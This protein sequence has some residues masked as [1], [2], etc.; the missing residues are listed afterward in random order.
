MDE[1]CQVTEAIQE[2]P[3]AKVCQNKQ[4]Y[5]IS[6]DLAE[7]LDLSTDTGDHVQICEEHY[8]KLSRAGLL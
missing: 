2:W 1:K 4:V 6:D 3:Y 8:A 5:E 7:S